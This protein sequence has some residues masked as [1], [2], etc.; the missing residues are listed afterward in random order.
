LIVNDTACIKKSIK[1]GERAQCAQKGL[2]RPQTRVATHHDT[3]VLGATHDGR[4]DGAGCV[5]TGE[6]GLAHAGTIVNHE[7]LNLL[8]LRGRKNGEKGA[9][10]DGK[11]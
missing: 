6:A 10:R 2:Q 4:E 11:H 7:C 8:S 5:I 1:A 3:G 9:K